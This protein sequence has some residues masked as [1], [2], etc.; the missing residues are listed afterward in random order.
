MNHLRVL[1]S[2]YHQEHYILDGFT[3]GFKI[4]YEGPDYCISLD[5]HRSAHTYH[6]QLLAKVQR[7]ITLGRVAGPFDK[8]PFTSCR[9][10][11]LGCIE[12]K[13]K[14]TYRMILDLSLPDN[15]SVNSFIPD[16]SSNVQYESFDTV[17]AHILKNGVGSLVAK[18]DI[19]DAF[20]IIPVHPQDYHLLCY[21]LDQSYYHDLVLPMGCRSSCKIFETFSSFL[22]WLIQ[23]VYG[24]TYVTHILDDFIFVGSP[25]TYSCMQGIRAFVAL[26]KYLRVPIKQSKTVYPTTTVSVYGIEIDTLAM[27]ARLPKEKIDKAMLLIDRLLGLDSCC[28]RDLQQLTG[29]LNFCCKVVPPGRAFLRRIWNLSSGLLSSKSRN[30]VVQLTASAKH[31]MSAWR[32]FLQQFNGVRLLDQIQYL[33]SNGHH[34]YT[35]ASSSVGY[36]AIMGHYWFYGTWG[37]AE[38]QHTILT[39][40]LVPIVMAL[41]MFSNLFRNKRLT[42][43]TDNLALVHILNRQSTHCKHTMRLIRKVVIRSL[44]FN[45]KIV[46]CHISSKNNLLCDLLSR[47]QVSEVTRQAPWL[48]QEPSLIPPECLPS[49]L[50]QTT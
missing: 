12:K 8:I 27:T 2:G 32:L 39:L 15:V 29:L 48:N 41:H 49:C 43:H 34:L 16:S 20:R 31:D 17:V 4:G 11:P 9:I 24:F 22:Q 42:I 46:A 14:G 30:R 26:C 23:R 7:E 3:Y 35:D 47:N 33:P 37:Q 18:A 44:L 45:V 25:G 28:L 21:K 50:L 36:G 5:N 6:D 1:L 13:E 38:K 19:E 40:E 10:N